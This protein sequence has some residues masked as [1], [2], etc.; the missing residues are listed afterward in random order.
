MSD[1]MKF[2]EEELESLADK[3]LEEASISDIVDQP[4]TELPKPGKRPKRKEGEQ[5][6]NK[7]PAER[8]NE[9]LEKGKKT[10][11][12]SAKELGLL[13]ELN[14]DA[15]SVDK[16]YETLEQNG[17][18]I[19]VAG[20]DALPPIDD[21]APEVEDLAQIEEVTEEEITDTDALIASSLE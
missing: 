5:V 7:T 1:E 9:L 20:A 12:L 21:V 2:T 14:L 17:V 19:D 4:E 15:D 11:R 13:E 8:L 3:L 10:G 18:D 6:S 16:F